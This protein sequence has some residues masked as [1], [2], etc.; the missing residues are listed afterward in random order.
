[1]AAVE[2]GS[3]TGAEFTKKAI[4]TVGKSSDIAQVSGYAFLSPDGNAW[5]TIPWPP[6]HKRGSDPEG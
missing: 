2:L 4:G 1:M 5:I 3:W 6:R